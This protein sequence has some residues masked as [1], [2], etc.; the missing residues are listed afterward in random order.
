[1]CLFLERESTS[2]LTAHTG[3]PERTTEFW[4]ARILPPL[5]GLALVYVVGFWFC[6]RRRRKRDKRSASSGGGGGRGYLSVPAFLGP[7]SS[8][9]SPAENK[10]ADDDA[11]SDV[12]P[13]RAS[14]PSEAPRH[15][16][17]AH[18]LN[19]PPPVYSRDAKPARDGHPNPNSMLNV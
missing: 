4:V 13:P 17:A 7:R 16:T 15:A 10:Y 18:P 11:S 1:M 5:L 8:R 9:H 14:K 6:R 2:Q 19:E 12:S 3:Q